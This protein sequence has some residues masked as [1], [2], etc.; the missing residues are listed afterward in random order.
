MYLQQSYPASKPN[1]SFKPNLLRYSKSVA[2]K[3]CHAFASTTQVGLTQALGSGMQKDSARGRRV[4]QGNRRGAPNTKL[5]RDG[6]APRGTA[7]TG[8]HRTC[9]DRSTHNRSLRS[10][11]HNKG[12]SRRRAAPGSQFVTL[13]RRLVSQRGFH[14]RPRKSRVSGTGASPTRAI[15]VANLSASGYNTLLCPPP[16]RGRC[17]TCRST[18]A[19]TACCLARAALPAYPAPRGQGSTPSSPG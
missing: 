13:L 10:N 18:G 7:R 11:Q 16:T 8:S 17:L 5:Q 3:A 2:E 14:H 1:N 4:H 19:P 15:S 12:A 6:Q 9:R